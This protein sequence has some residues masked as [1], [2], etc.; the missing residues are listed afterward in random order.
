MIRH[1]DG[2]Q[3]CAEKISAQSKRGKI[4]TVR[5]NYDKMVG[6]RIVLTYKEADRLLGVWKRWQERRGHKVMKSHRWLRWYPPEHV[7]NV[8]KGHH[9]YVEVYDPHTRRKL[10]E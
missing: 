2:T 4:I 6:H 7:G 8:V 5:W 3:E 1:S 9:C 10:W